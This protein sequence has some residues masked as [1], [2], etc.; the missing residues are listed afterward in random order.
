MFIF[1]LFTVNTNMWDELK[2]HW[3]VFSITWLRWSAYRNRFVWEVLE[4][5]KTFLFTYGF[6][7]DKPLRMEVEEV[8]E[9]LHN[10]GKGHG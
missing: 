3:E 9:K 8:S 5:V 1:A 2:Y 4:P 6:L 10:K 7:R